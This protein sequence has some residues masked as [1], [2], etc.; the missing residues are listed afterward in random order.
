[1]YL[2]CFPPPSPTQVIYPYQ[3]PLRIVFYHSYPEFLHLFRY[4]LR[5]SHIFL[6]FIIRALSAFRSFC[7][8]P[9]LEAKVHYLFSLLAFRALLLHLYSSLYQLKPSL[10][11]LFVIFHVPFVFLSMLCLSLFFAR[12]LRFS[13][14]FNLLIG[15]SLFNLLL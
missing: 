4:V 14:L 2:S 11:S 3:I 8:L 12:F 7:L 9:I 10:S 5:S 6:S 1:M 15:C 13:I